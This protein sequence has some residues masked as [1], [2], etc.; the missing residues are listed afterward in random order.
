MLSVILCS[1][2]LA[3][4]SHKTTLFHTD[5]HFR[6]SKT[7]GQAISNWKNP[8]FSNEIKDLARIV[9]AGSRKNVSRN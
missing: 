5:A 6:V 9:E 1:A 4:K 8:V 3:E 7:G 2:F